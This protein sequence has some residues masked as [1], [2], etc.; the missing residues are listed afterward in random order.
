MQI[1]V[2]IP[3]RKDTNM[4]AELQKVKDLDLQSCQISIWNPDFYTDELAAEIN[5]AVEATGIVVSTLWAGYSGPIEWNFTQGPL[6]LG[7]VPP[8]YRGIR[9]KELLRASE[10]ATKINCVNIATH[11]GFIPENYH[12]PEFWGT[13]GV[14]RGICRTLKARGAYS[15][16][17][18]R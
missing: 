16:S 13:V 2:M 6:V 5:A 18:K 8:A 12:D 7:L 10:F 3:V 17:S 1:G 11:A 15:A 4:L 9:E 14:L